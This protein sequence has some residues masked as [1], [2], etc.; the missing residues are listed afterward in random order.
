MSHG[1]QPRR[2]VARFLAGGILL[3]LLLGPHVSAA[4]N[5]PD[6][7][8]PKPRSLILLPMGKNAVVVE[9]SSQQLFL[10]SCDSQGVYERLRVPCSTGASPG[11]KSRSGDRK[12]PEGVYFLTDAYEDRYLS[13]V[14]GKKAFPTDYPNLIDRRRGR[15]G[16]AIWLH[17]TNKPLR[18]MDSNGCVAMNNQD[19]LRLAPYL[20]PGE[21]PVV[22]THMVVYD[23]PAAIHH[24]QQ[25]LLTLLSQWEQAIESGTD[26]DYLM[27]YDLDNLPEFQWWKTWSAMRQRA[28]R[29]G[30]CFKVA[31]D[32][33]GI[34]REGE[35][36]VIFFDMALVLGSRRQ[37]LGKRKLFVEKK[38]NKYWITG[39][40]FQT[41]PKG[42]MGSIGILAE[43]AETLYPGD[44]SVPLQ[45]GQVNQ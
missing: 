28:A 21:T 4:L 34:Y 6:R 17:G 16:S 31:I 40:L 2:F 45:Q 8:D 15:N 19:I 29:Q 5:D 38:R 42:E 11:R 33:P 12:T 1:F 27:R 9:K 26:Q 37:A 22:L 24:E 13:A 25:A 43:A 39:D 7:P 23:E 41:F 14:Y 10:F 32:S 20:V 3:G 35:V 36:F 30:L 18:P 44:D